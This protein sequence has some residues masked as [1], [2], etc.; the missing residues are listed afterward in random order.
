MKNILLPS[1]AFILIGLISIGIVLFAFD[2]AS[3]GL[4]AAFLTTGSFSLQVFD[5]LKTRETKAISTKMYSVFISGVLLWLI[6]GLK[7]GD[8][9]ITVANSLT[10]MLACS[11]MVLKWI[12]ERNN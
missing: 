5:I 2:T 12:N 4:C 11:V 9:P 8:T 3:L 1:H 10:L 7:T 6:Y